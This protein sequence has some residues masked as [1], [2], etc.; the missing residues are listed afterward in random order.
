V[1]PGAAPTPVLY[2]AGHAGAGARWAA[3]LPGALPAGWGVRAIVLPGREGRAREPFAP[4]LAAVAD[5]AA[6]EVAAHHP[7]DRPAALFGQS[8]GALLA[9]E[10]C[11]RLEAGGPAP[12]GLAVL[13]AP[14]PARGPPPGREDRSD[15]GL[16]R[17]LAAYGTL[18]GALRDAEMCA[19]ILETVRSDMRLF[20]GYAWG[21][22]ARV[23]APLAALRGADDRTVASEEVDAWGAHAGGAFT[24]IDVPGGH[25]PT[26]AAAAAWAAWRPGGAHP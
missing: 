26:A 17:A 8:L 24:R 12:T 22:D 7:A 4:S 13:G 23:R 11:L 5:A 10:L 14:A 16:L 3:A 1:V 19:W 9:L 20:D 25:L 2:A 15:E 21:T 6:A 18:S